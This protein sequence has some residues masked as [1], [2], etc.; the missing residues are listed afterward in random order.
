[1][2]YNKYEELMYSYCCVYYP[3]SEIVLAVIVLLK[4]LAYLFVNFISK[5]RI[6]LICSYIK[7]IYMYSMIIANKDF[8]GKDL[9]EGC[10]Q[11]I[12]SNIMCFAYMWV[13]LFICI[14]VKLSTTDD[15]LWYVKI[16]QLSL[17]NV[18]LEVVCN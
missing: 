14:K 10:F 16:I 5:K 18:G 4:L 11:L 17:I 12:V 1:M 13:Y 3:N 9:R 8:E 2:N 6:R 15:D 7:V